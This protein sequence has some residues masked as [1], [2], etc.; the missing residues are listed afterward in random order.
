MVA[1]ERLSDHDEIQRLRG[2]VEEHV[3]STGSKKGQRLL[4]NWSATVDAFI[5]VFPNEWRRV[6]VERSEAA[7]ERKLVQRSEIEPRQAAG[8]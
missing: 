8:G 7:Q 2:L 4:A 1:L 5:K 6:L 3:Q